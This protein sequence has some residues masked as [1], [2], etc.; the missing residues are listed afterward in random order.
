MLERRRKKNL[1]LGIP[2]PSCNPGGHWHTARGG[3]HTQQIPVFFL[4]I[5]MHRGKTGGLQEVSY[6]QEV[7]VPEWIYSNNKYL[8]IYIYIFI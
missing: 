3:G 4:M 1:E 2:E 7:S 6:F 8:F 5:R